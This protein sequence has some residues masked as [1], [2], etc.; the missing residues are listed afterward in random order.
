MRTHDLYNTGYMLGEDGRIWSPHKQRHL[1]LSTNKNGY[2][3][4]TIPKGDGNSI[5]ILVHREIWRA[6]KS[7]IPFGGLQ[8]IDHDKMNPALDNLRPKQ[9]GWQYVE[10]IKQG[11]TITKI[12]KYY[13]MPKKV[14]S[15][16]VSILVPGGIRE[17]RKTYPL[18]KSK[19]IQW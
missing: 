4:T 16:V 13:D 5:G 12:A 7:E 19:D 14:V 1:Q 11:I 8:H 10:Y 9:P 3:F 17:L 2:A 15:E 18:N 6:F